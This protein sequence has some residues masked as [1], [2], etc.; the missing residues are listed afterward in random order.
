[1]NVLALESSCDET[2]IAVVK[3]GKSLVNLV[4]S[5]HLLHERFGGVVPEL[6][7]RRHVEI[8]TPLLR[9]AL[10][11][12]HLTMN[13]IEGVA[14]TYGPGLVGALLVGLCTAKG[15]AMAKKIPFRGVHH[16]EGHI[17]AA[18]L[19]HASL[20]YPHIV[21]VVS[22]GHT[23]LY[24]VKA[25]GDYHLLGATRDDAAGEAFDKVAKLL[26]LGF[27]GG[28]ALDALSQ[29]G[30]AHAFRFPFPHF[31]DP[32]SLEFSFSGIKTAVMLLVRK[33]TPLSARMKANIAASFQHAVVETLMKQTRE[34]VKRTHAHAVVISGGVAANRLLRKRITEEA[35]LMHIPC[36]IPSPHFCTDN[37]AMIG[38]VG[39][40]YLRLG[41]VSPLTLNAVAHEEIGISSCLSSH[42]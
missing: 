35:L 33:L 2:A 31:D 27:P 20:P 26:D 12:A 15:I 8:I 29:H 42:S 16:I 34:A 38:Y 6:A 39:E 22:G 30:D 21:L 23:H 28:P 37:A 7:S 18:L 32:H 5:Q 14:A 9:E 13:E 40:R 41:Q 10:S 25:F 19:E 24:Q 1:M 17:I 4:A 36:F 3:D 11:E